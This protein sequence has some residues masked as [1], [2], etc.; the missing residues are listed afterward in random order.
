MIRT[1]AGLGLLAILAGAVVI[2]DGR[3]DLPVADFE[4]DDYGAWT[5]TGEAFGPGPARG[6][7]PGQM[8][9][10]GF[11]GERLVNSFFRGDGTTG[12]L[13]SPEFRIERKRINLLVGGGR[14]PGEACVNLLVGG[15]V[16]RTAT[17][18][19]SEY[20]RPVSWDVAELEGNAARIEV[21]DRETGGW[22]HINVDQIVQSDTGPVIRDDLLARANAS[23]EAAGERVKNDPSRPAFHVLAPAQWIND[24]NGP[25][26]YKGYYHLFYQHNPYGDEWGNMHWGH[27]RSKDLAHWEHLPIALWP[28]KPLGEDHVFSGSATI[29]PDGRPLIFY[30]SIGP[31]LPEQWAAVP[32]DDD[33]IRWTKHP[34][35]PI[36]TETLHGETKV[37]E[38]RDPFVF[39][40]NERTYIVLGG[41]LNGS[42]G[43]EGVVN[44]Y[45]AENE[46]LTEWSYLGVL[47]RHPDPEVKNVECPLFFPL[48]GRWVLIVSQGRPV[49][50]FVG[51]L[52]ES[53]MRFTPTSRGKLDFGE[54]YAPNVLMNDPKGRK[55]LWGWVNGYPGGKGWRHCL[56][57]PRVLSIGDD[58]TLRQRP[59]PELEQ[60]RG[61]GGPGPALEAKFHI[62]PG[63]RG[64]FDLQL[65]DGETDM[66]A[67]RIRFDGE[68]LDL[69]GTRAPVAR[70]PGDGPL[71]VQ[72]FY[73][74]GLVELYADD[75]RVCLTRVLPSP[76]PSARMALRIDGKNTGKPEALL[77]WPIESIWIDR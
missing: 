42:Q 14:H 39:R 31:R 17:G 65:T 63:D 16:A 67:A 58:G 12:T 48:D 44:V 56:T 35:N 15:K 38:W 59:A 6:A 21:V 72:L 23:T 52:D 53:T 68:A 77:V 24:P 43:G 29:G 28:S 50:W 32:E 20:L 55:V 18:H 25:I 45:R 30:T 8:A 33:L 60:L 46:A 75:G 64:T 5:A 73:D 70:Q 74:H 3:R 76:A 9:V 13:T 62:D 37:Y 22:G 26:Y 27:G 51:D 47:F 7:L 19:D 1:I 2:D 61:S 57:L 34:A 36:L 49:D 71:G 11:E 54:V 41:N 4:A 66:P 40:A 10:G 69:E